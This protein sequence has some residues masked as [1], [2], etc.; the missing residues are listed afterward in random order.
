MTS[1]DRLFRRRCMWRIARDLVA[2]GSG[3]LPE[4]QE[5]DQWHPTDTDWTTVL[6]LADLNGV[7]PLLLLAYQAQGRLHTLPANVQ[8]HLRRA[9][10]NTLSRAHWILPHLHCLIQ[11]LQSAKIAFLILKGFPLI[12]QLY[13]DLGARPSYD[14]DFW[15]RDPHDAQ[16]AVDIL[17]KLGYESVPETGSRDRDGH[18]HLLPLWK[19]QPHPQGD[20]FHPRLPWTVE[21]HVALWE[22]NW[23]GLTLKPITGIWERHT[24]VEVDGLRVPVLDLAD[25]LLYLSVH[26][27]L[28]IIAG[29]ARLLHLHDLHRLC[30][31]LG[32]TDWRRAWSLAEAAG[33]E[34]F[35]AAAVR[36]TRT[37][38]H[39]TLPP[40]AE[41]AM[42][43]SLAGRA[44]RR[45][46]EA[47]A[48][49]ETLL[50]DR[51][52]ANIRTSRMG[53]LSALFARHV[54]QKPRAFLQPILATTLPP[55]P[56]LRRKYGLRDQQSVAPYYIWH[57]LQGVAK[58]VG[59]AFLRLRGHR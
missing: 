50:E 32:A 41:E 14:I 56:F 13:G 16:R 34:V 21:P 53:W 10:T 51:T 30:P 12:L 57:F 24:T 25:K 4:W 1:D 6:Y 59:Q 3:S 46:L 54:W 31:M 18:R 58:L 27:M 29:N 55:A 26:E 22:T 19:P 37:I 44:V 35:L 33:L 7:T 36:L 45:W 42:A 2:G 48:A 43:K 40:E 15:L 9:H 28:H 47:G 17:L 38:F 11:E 52:A 23:W 5:I 39:T 49:D 20:L 8:A